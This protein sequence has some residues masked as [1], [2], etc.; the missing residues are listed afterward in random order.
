MKALH[1]VYSV[2]ESDPRVRRHAEAL[3]GAGWEVSVLAIAEPPADLETT[4]GPV[5]VRNLVMPRYRGSA[6]SEY[7]RGYR[8][9][10]QWALAQAWRQSPGCDYVQIHTPPDFAII[11]ALPMRIRSTPVVLD[12]HDL[13]PE[14]FGDRF[15]GRKRWARAAI[16]FSERLSTATASHVLTVSETFRRRLA[17]RGVPGDK[18]TVIMN[19]PDPA[20]FW[21]D[22]IP[23]PPDR[24]VLSYHGTLVP[25]YGP[26]VLLD[27]AALLVPEFP[28]LTVRIV[29]DGDQKPQLEARA[30]R[31]DLA[32]RVE[33][34]AGRV[35][36]HEIPVALGRVS[37]GV[38]A[39]RHDGFGR[40]V[41]STK[42]MEYLALGIPAVITRTEGLTDYFDPGPLYTVD[43]ATP[44]AFAGRLREVLADPAAAAARTRR[45][46]R[47]FDEHHWAAEAER[48]LALVDR[49][50]SG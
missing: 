5:S 46:R 15:G 17:D 40:L 9:F 7:L 38:V 31:Q 23:P 27:A 13:T 50:A 47:F 36:T 19:L 25:R 10:V 49:L 22:L 1:I 6:V 24:P 20:I 2:Y 4:V 41:L 30:A 3:A 34:S 28:E 45:A 29:G 16:R 8:R 32:G 33:F 11:S 43:H 42:F 21:R 26:D 12:I 44:E 14:L 18:L 37:A 39:N 35:P 48:Y